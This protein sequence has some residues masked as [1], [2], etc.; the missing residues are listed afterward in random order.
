MADRQGIPVY[1][2]KKKEQEIFDGFCRGDVQQLACCEMLAA[3]ITILPINRGILAY[4]SG[5]SEQ[6]AQKICRML[7]KEVFNPNKKAIIDLIDF[8]ESFSRIRT[9]TALNMFD[10]TKINYI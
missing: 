1:H 9:A 3:G 2:S 8:D 6:A 7:G 10:N 4:V 5:A